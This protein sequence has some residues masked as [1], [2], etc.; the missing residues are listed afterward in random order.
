MFGR[1]KA[2]REANRQAM[3]QQ[4]SIERANAAQQAA[5]TLAANRGADLSM[6]NVANVNTG[7]T[8]GSNS[9]VGGVVEPPVGILGAGLG[10]D[11]KR[12]RLGGLA[13]Q[14]GVNL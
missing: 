12:K 6:E 3:L 10:P 1:K 9:A 5:A 11:G 13:S 14:L 4:Q 7:M 8:A 2:K